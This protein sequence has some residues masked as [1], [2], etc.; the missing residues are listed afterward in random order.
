[1]FEPNMRVFKRAIFLLFI[2]AL[3]L[4]SPLVIIWILV[5]QPTTVKNTASDEKIDIS[6]LQKLNVL[7]DFPLTFV[8]YLVYKALSYSLDAVY[9]G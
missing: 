2:I 4:I 6:K 3:L 5:A 9:E 1:M 8:R 7:P